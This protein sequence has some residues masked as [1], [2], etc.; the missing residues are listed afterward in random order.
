MAE[1]LQAFSYSFANVPI[2]LAV[3]ALELLGV[4]HSV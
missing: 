3:C 2:A 4:L 1:N